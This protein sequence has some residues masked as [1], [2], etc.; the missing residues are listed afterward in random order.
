[1]TKEYK[2]LRARS[3]FDHFDPK[4]T[5]A[6]MSDG[7]PGAMNAMVAM[8]QVSTTGGQ[9][10]QWCW[11]MVKICD[12]LEIYGSRL[13]QLWN[14]CFDRSFERMADCAMGYRAGKISAA[15]IREKIQGDGCRGFGFEPSEVWCG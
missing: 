8:L 11:E 1:M 13:Y 2:I 6:K 10:R 3:K 14:D 12:E 4:R 15:F 7:N 9:T 5:I